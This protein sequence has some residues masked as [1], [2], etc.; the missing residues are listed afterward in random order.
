MSVTTH[1]ETHLSIIDKV[2]NLHSETILPETADEAMKNCLAVVR[3]VDFADH[4][5]CF[6]PQMEESLAVSIRKTSDTI[7]VYWHVVGNPD[8]ARDRMREV[9]RGEA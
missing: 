5:D 9:E 3:A 7:E 2:L 1:P 4:C 6:D 8:V